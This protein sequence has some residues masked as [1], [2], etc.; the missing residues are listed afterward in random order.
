MP[1]VGLPGRS[2]AILDCA[3]VRGVTPQGTLSSFRFACSASTTIA[4]VFAVGVFAACGGGSFLGPDERQYPRV[5]I[6]TAALPDAVVGTPYNF[7]FTATGGSGAFFW[8]LQP[9]SAL[10]PGIAMDPDG[11][12]SGTPTTAGR[13][14]FT[15]QAR[16]ICYCAPQREP[17][18][19]IKTFDLVVR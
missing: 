4:V 5:I 2:S 10:P 13:T 14:T 11:R 12:L 9:G 7:Q 3:K 18:Q 19:D 17:Q 8:S 6:T 16:H 15:V 1:G